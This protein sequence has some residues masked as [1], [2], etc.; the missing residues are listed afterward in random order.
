MFTRDA[1]MTTMMP[2][3]MPGP[4]AGVSCVRTGDVA[5]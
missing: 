3:A 5:G 2:M 4:G 1:H